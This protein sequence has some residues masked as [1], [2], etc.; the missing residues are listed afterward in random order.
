MADG[1]KWRAFKV[2]ATGLG[3]LTHRTYSYLVQLETVVSTVRQDKCPADGTEI[4]LPGCLRM[5]KVK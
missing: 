1:Q 2:T 4:E 3:V 5:G